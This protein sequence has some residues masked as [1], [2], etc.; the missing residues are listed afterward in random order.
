MQQNVSFP[1]TPL[2]VLAVAL[3]LS[4]V[5]TGAGCDGFY[6]HDNPCSEY[7]LG[8]IPSGTHYACAGHV[9]TS[10]KFHCEVHDGG[11]QI[12]QEVLVSG[13]DCATTGRSCVAEYGGAVCVHLCESDGE[14]GGAEFC[15]Y[16]VY[17]S[18]GVCGARAEPGEHCENLHQDNGGAPVDVCAL[19]YACTILPGGQVFESMFPGD[20]GACDP[21]DE[22]GCNGLN[23]ECTCQPPAKPAREQLPDA[24]STSQAAER[25]V[26]ALL[27]LPID[28]PKA[29]VPR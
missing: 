6:P 18:S 13:E 9:I 2:R 27:L 10:Q 12:V 29:A 24:P 15:S 23:T 3:A 5:L 26:Q 4:L 1:S 20:G 7:N 28:Y 17:A 16:D 8:S 21:C 22:F 25:P 19:G 11:S 14:C